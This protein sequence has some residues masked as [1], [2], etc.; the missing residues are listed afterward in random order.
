M[1]TQPTAA[2]LIIGN[3]ILSGRTKDANLAWLAAQLS[4]AG[5]RL[6]EVRVVA[7]IAADIIA[8][9]NA[10]RQRYTY[11]FTTGGIGPTHD[12]ITTACMAEAFSVPVIRHPDAEA[13]L[14]KHYK[15]EDI[16]AA[17]LKMADVPQGA[18]LVPNPVSAAPGYRMENVYVFAGVPRIMQ[19]MFDAIRHELVGGEPIK[20]KTISAY[21]TEGWIAEGL[22][23]I[24]AQFL[25]V[26]IGSYPFIRDG[27]LGT[28]LVMRGVDEARLFSVLAALQEMLTQ[29]QA[30][31]LVE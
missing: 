27:R 25:D 14:R 16:N 24:Q 6:L 4:E 3:E 19:A 7:D 15:P 2:L 1:N 10:L 12:D 20:S 11:L 8:A 9:V 26:E 21:I 28:S 22:T 30:E 23:A 13:A 17:R 5:I 18:T 29:L 31:M